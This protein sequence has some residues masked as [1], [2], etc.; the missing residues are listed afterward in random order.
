M[1]SRSFFR[2]TGLSFCLPGHA[3]RKGKTSTNCLTTAWRVKC[4]LYFQPGE[5]DGLTEK[6]EIGETKNDEIS[7]RLCR[8]ICNGWCTPGICALYWR[9]LA[10]Q[11]S[12][13]PSENNLLAWQ[14]QLRQTLGKV[15]TLFV[16]LNGKIFFLTETEKWQKDDWTQKDLK[17]SQGQIKRQFWESRRESMS[18]R[19]TN[20]LFLW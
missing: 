3:Y 18:A 9:Q 16:S 5:P 10:K 17:R 14:C 19:Q 4:P 1:L 6:K 2:G 12:S 13:S 8:L 15:I 20:K 7:W 11:K